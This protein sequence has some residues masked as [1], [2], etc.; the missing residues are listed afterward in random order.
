MIWEF[1]QQQQIGEAR[2][3][4]AS[5]QAKARS[6]SETVRLLEGR[7]DRL[8]L[9]NRALWELLRDALQVDDEFLKNKVSEIDLRDGAADGKSRKIIKKC[10]QCGRTLNRRHDKCLYCGAENL[11]HDVFDAV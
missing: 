3:E 8:V 11:S 4:A 2:G 5:A 9:V 10:P 1:Y 7:I 6:V